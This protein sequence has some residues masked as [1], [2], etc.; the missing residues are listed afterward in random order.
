MKMTI[1]KL[2]VVVAVSCSALL[3][4]GREHPVTLETRTMPKAQQPPATTMTLDELSNVLSGLTLTN[5]VRQEII[6]W[7]NKAG[8]KSMGITRDGGLWFRMKF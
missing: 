8:D 3:G 6:V 4:C 7:T 1:Q 5:C 2:V